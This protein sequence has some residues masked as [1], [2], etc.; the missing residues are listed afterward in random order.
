MNYKL[1]YI[2]RLFQK[3][4]RKAI[5]N[6]CLTRLWHRLVNDEI[7][8]VPQQYV[9]RHTDKYA[10]TDVYLPQFKIHIEVNEPA[11]YHSP[12]R[13]KADEFRKQQVESKSGH[14]LYV[15][16]CRQDILQIHK[17]IE[18]IVQIINIALADQKANCTFKPWQPDIERNPDYWKSKITINVI[19]D[20]SFNSIED[21]CKLFDAD[22]N[23]TK[24]GFLRQGGLTHPKNKNYFLWWPSDN[25]R[26]GWLNVL[27][28]DDLEITE[29]HSDNIKN[30]EHYN[31]CLNTPEIR[32]VFFHYKDILGLTSYRFKGVYAYDNVKSKPEKGTVWK[33]ISDNLKIGLN[34]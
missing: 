7:I 19:D 5:E 8:I 9:N 4:S 34:D 23:K 11:H 6:Y 14:K 25:K 17:Q 16:D 33:R 18:D 10:L 15:I 32:I 2:T 13:I 22:F 20:I 31:K 27:S 24:R 26:F 28:A 3:T 30:A 1:E 29:S 12:E 21:I